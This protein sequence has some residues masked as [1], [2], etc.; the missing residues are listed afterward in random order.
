MLIIV[1]ARGGSKG[2][3][4]K[5]SRDFCGHA[6]VDWSLSAALYLQKKITGASV[7]LTTDCPKIL[8]FAAQKYSYK[9]TTHKRPVALSSDLATMADV[10]LDAAK[11]SGMGRTGRY[12]LLQPTS[13]LRLLSDLTAFAKQAPKEGAQVSCTLPAEDPHELID[14]T[15]CNALV[16]AKPATRRQDRSS[17]LRFVDGSLYAGDLTQLEQTGSFMPAQKTAFLPLDIPRAIDIDT[18]L[19]WHFGIALYDWLMKN[20]VP[21]VGPAP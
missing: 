3:P 6:L 15:S 16:P 7:H 18:A 13:P 2:L 8:A 1:P 9:I 10:V 21:F 14:I 4:G 5:N 19:D 20:E 17:C 11:F 12:V